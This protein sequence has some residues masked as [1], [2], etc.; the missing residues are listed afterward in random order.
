[1]AQIVKKRKTRGTPF[2]TTPF[3]Q[4]HLFEF[5]F[6]TAQSEHNSVVTCVVCLFCKRLGRYCAM[7]DDGRERNRTSNTKYW[8]LSFHKENFANHLT[9]QHFDDFAEYKALSNQEKKKFFDARKHVQESMHPYLNSMQTVLTI[10]ISKGIIEVIIGDMFFKPELDED[11][12]EMELI[13]NINTLK[14]FHQQDDGTYVAKVSNAILHNL[15]L[16]HTLVG[17]SFRQMSTVIGQHK[18]VFGNEKLVGFN[19]HEVGMM[20]RVNVGANLQVLSNV[21]NHH[22]V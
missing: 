17:L 10:P 15:T 7:E 21:L 8:N 18:D 16:Q 4:K 1:M 11:D 12:E 14:L 22:D 20:V 9:L 19:D 5:G 6:E 3:Q 2:R 13:T